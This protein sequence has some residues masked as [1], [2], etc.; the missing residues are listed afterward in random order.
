MFTTPAIEQL[1]PINR[2]E[3][4]IG[5]PTGVTVYSLDQISVTH[6]RD[7]LPCLSGN[8]QLAWRSTCIYHTD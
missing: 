8:T 5:N 2:V 6:N 7:V 3:N 4:Y 1:S